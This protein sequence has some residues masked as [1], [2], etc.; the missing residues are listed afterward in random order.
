MLC[1]V[2]EYMKGKSKLDKEKTT[3]N[4]QLLSGLVSIIM[5][6]YNGEKFIKETIESV[7]AQTYTSW[8][9][10]IIDDGS[11]DSSVDIIKNYQQDKR[12]KLIQQANAGSAAARNNGIRNAKGQYIALL[13]SDDIWFP[14]F[15]QEQVSF[16][17]NKNTV[18]VYSAYTRI[19]EDSNEILGPVKVKKHISLK[20]MMAVDQIGCLTGLYDREKY[21]KIYLHEELK[22]LFDDYAY[23]IDI[24]KL[25]DSAYGNPKVLAKYRVRENSMTSNKKKLIIKHY[26]FYRNYLKEG[27]IQSYISVL[28]WGIQGFI[29]YKAKIR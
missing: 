7:L 26:N 28:Q 18:C 29:K 14:N 17:K 10:L 6:C 21:G 4:E 19:D 24:V 3:N 12:I 8:E 2:R 20:D 22:S 25:E 13:D 1:E 5:P 11:K 15:L 23:W 9:L 16:I 27:R